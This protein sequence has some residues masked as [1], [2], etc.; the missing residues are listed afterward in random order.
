MVILMF[1][2]HCL[3]KKSTIISIWDVGLVAWKPF[4][5]SLNLCLICWT[6]HT[7]QKLVSV[8]HGISWIYLLERCF[9]MF[10]EYHDIPVT[11][12][13]V[14]YPFSLHY[15]VTVFVL[16][17]LLLLPFIYFMLFIRF[18]T[19]PG[20]TRVNLVMGQQSSAQTWIPVGDSWQSEKEK[21]RNVQICCHNIGRLQTI[22]CLCF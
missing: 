4:Q 10:L 5:I 20:G 8:F 7:K 11:Q 17:L 16:L 21:W 22:C 9:K 15:I 6:N 13:S 19:I 18:A 1:I 3:Y 12:S 2:K 14:S